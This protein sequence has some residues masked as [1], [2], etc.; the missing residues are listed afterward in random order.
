MTSENLKHGLVKLRNWQ[1]SV[2]AFTLIELLIV[3]A[4]IAILAALLIPQLVKSKKKAA[5]ATAL[6]NL[7]NK[8]NEYK[9]KLSN[10][11][12]VD[13]DAANTEIQNLYNTLKTE[14]GDPYAMSEGPG[15]QQFQL[16]ITDLML[17]LDGKINNTEDEK[18]TLWETFKST[19]GGIKTTLLGSSS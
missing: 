18:K 11:E 15:K 19:V 1:K 5:C 8:L 14:C 9:N 4:I 3:I 12:S 13:P 6:Q 7:Q 16:V 2:L 17:Q 10:N